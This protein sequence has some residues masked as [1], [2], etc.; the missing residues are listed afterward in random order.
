[1]DISDIRPDPT[2]PVSPVQH[3]REDARRAA[4]DPADRDGARGDD[5]VDI[6]EHGR[7]LSRS[8]PDATPSGTLPADRLIDVRRK[9]QARFYDRVEVAEEVARRIIERGDI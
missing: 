2:G 3:T 8:V 1:M 5:R 7:A 9:V 4:G 6:S